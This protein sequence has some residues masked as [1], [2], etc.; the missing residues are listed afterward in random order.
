M[1][2]F[3]ET[4]LSYNSCVEGQESS[5][6]S[7]PSHD[8]MSSGNGVGPHKGLEGVHYLRS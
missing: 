1:V 2:E 7:E 6:E 3:S 4:D 8:K 5:G